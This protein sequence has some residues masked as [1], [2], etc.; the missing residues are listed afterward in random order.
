LDALSVQMTPDGSR[1]I[2]W[3]INRMIKDASDR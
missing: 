3:M 1:R 2:L